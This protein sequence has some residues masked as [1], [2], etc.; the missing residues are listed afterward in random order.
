M[1]RKLWA[2]E[3]EDILR[4]MYT[5]HFADEI[6][7]KLGRSKLSIYCHAASLGLKSSKEKII[8]AGKLS[9]HH[10]NVVASQFKKGHISFNKGK[11]M[12][13]EIYEK[14]KAT[15]FKKGNIPHNYKPVGSERVNVDGYVEIKVGDPNRWRLKHRVIWE[16]ANGE[17]PEGY[18]VQFKNG[19]STD[20]RLDNLYLISKAEQMK[21]ENSIY[22]RYPEEL[23]E[24]I[25][26]K[27]AIKRQLTER[28]KKG[29]GKQSKS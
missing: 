21:T 1:M 9:C 4:Q 17:I 26:L 23:R 18:N 27:G 29:N 13:P 8:E 12:P 10:P 22:A 25:R 20:V 5:D 15:M 2:K 24:V 16:E 11:K 6:A 3:E 14:A 7:E 28:R 19:N